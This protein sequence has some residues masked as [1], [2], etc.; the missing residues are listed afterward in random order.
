MKQKTTLE[1]S[2]E[3]KTFFVLQKLQ[4]LQLFFQI[5]KILQNAILSP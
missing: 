5:K 4:V 1:K 3:K 2:A